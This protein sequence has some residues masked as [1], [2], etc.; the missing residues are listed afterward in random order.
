MLRD[1]IKSHQKYKK[2]LFFFCF[3]PP[4]SLFSSSIVKFLEKKIK[5]QICLLG[6]EWMGVKDGSG[7]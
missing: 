5:R 1:Y 3:F 6:Q 2:N 7:S 4:V